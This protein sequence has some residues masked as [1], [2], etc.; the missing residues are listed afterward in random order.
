MNRK[1]W[2]VCLGLALMSGLFMF[3]CSDNDDDN[4]PTGPGAPTLNAPADNATDVA[5]NP[6]A[7]SWTAVSAATGY[8]LHVGT[9]AQFSTLVV[10]QDVGAATSYNA[11]GLSYGTDY[12]WEVEARDASG[13][14]SMSAVHSFT[15]VGALVDTWDA[16][17]NW[18]DS[19]G[20]DQMQ[21]EFSST[22]YDWMYS[23]GPTNYHRSG[24]YTKTATVITFHETNN[25]GTPVDT[26]Y[27]RDYALSLPY[28]T[29]TV[30]YREGSTVYDILYD[31]LP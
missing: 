8:T 17:D 18:M 31:R 3:G 23:A 9:D 19:L 2:I 5:I 16:R 13:N 21:Y 15:A 24:T 14:T 20:I 1:L 22:S 6:T 11:N 4:T 28:T 7:F 12:F 10:N 26:T 29:L 25:D 27:S 30:E